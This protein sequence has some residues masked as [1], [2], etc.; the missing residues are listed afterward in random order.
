M[1]ARWHLIFNCI[2]LN[3]NLLITIKIS[4]KFVPKGPIYNIPAALVQ[5]MI[6][7]IDSDNSLSPGWRQAI[8][9]I[10]GGYFTDAYMRH[11][12]SVS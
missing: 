1:D 5:V 9:W 3:E 12:T 4:P 7:T 8:I 11:S 2:F 6:T 10:N